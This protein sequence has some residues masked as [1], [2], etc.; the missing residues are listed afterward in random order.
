[1]SFFLKITSSKKV[2]SPPVINCVPLFF[3]LHGPAHGKESNK[4]NLAKEMCVHVSALTRRFFGTSAK[5]MA[6]S[7]PPRPPYFTQRGEEMAK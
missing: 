5:K 6:E 7:F 1:M 2:L 3:F 4:V